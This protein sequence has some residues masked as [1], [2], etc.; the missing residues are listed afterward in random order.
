M[1]SGYPF[2]IVRVLLHAGDWSYW[3]PQTP[4]GGERAEDVIERDDGA[5][6]SLPSDGA[7]AEMVVDCETKDRA[8][9]ALE[10]C[11]A[12]EQSREFRV[13]VDRDFRAPD[14]RQLKAAES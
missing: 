5:W 1:R 7:I 10:R 8:L 3:T 13:C 11:Q 2:R 9:A 12:N 6:L 14:R 4:V